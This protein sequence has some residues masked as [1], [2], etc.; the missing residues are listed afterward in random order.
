MKYLH[1]LGI[2]H[3]DLKPGNVL[4]DD[5]LYPQICDF[6]CSFISDKELSKIQMEDPQGTPIYMAP[7]LYSDDPYSYQVDIYAFSLIMY[8][9]ITGIRPFSEY[10]SSYK[11]MKDVKNGVRPKLPKDLDENISSF[12]KRCW[13]NDPSERPAF[14]EIVEFIQQ[15]NFRKIFDIDQDELTNYLKNFD[16]DLKNPFLFHNF[17]VK[18]ASE[19]GDVY[20]THFMGIKYLFGIGVEKNSK[21]AASYFEK[22][23]N[24][25]DSE[26]MFNLG[27]M[28]EKGNDIEAD[29][30][31]ASS[32]YRKAIE[33]GNV[34]AMVNLA[35][36]LKDGK[37]IKMNIEEAAKLFK[38]AADKGDIESMNNYGFL[39]IEK[40]IKNDNMNEA[41]FYFKSA[42]DQGNTDAMINYGRSLLIN[43]AEKNYLNK[44]SLYFKKAAN[45][46]NNYANLLCGFMLWKG[47]GGKK[48][49]KNAIQYFNK[50]VDQA[51]DKEYGI[52]TSFYQIKSFKKED[53]IN[54]LK[55]LADDKKCDD[56]IKYEHC[57]YINDETLIDFTELFI[58]YKKSSIKGDTFSMFA[59]G[60]MMQ[61]GIGIT[62]N[63]EEGLSY[64]KM[65]ADHGNIP[66]MFEYASQ[67]YKSQ[68]FEEASEYFKLAADYKIDEKV[69][70]KCKD[71][72]FESI[73]QSITAKHINDAIILKGDSQYNKNKTTDEILGYFNYNAKILS[74]FF[75]SNM[76]FGMGISKDIEKA[77]RYLKIGIDL[78]DCKSMLR[79]GLMLHNGEGIPINKEESIKYFKMAADRGNVKAYHYYG[80]SLLNGIGIEVNKTEAAKYLKMGA[81]AND[82]DSSLLYGIMLLDGDGIPANNKESIKYIKSA[83]DNGNIKAYYFYGKALYNG[84]GVTKN[85]KE[86]IK[87]FKKGADKK[88]IDAMMAYSEVLIEGNVVPKNLKEGIRIL[89]N[90]ADLGNVSSCYKYGMM[91]SE[92]ILIKKDIKEAIKY[93][94]VA[95]EKND[96]D[97][98]ISLGYIYYIGDGVPVNK[99]KALHYIKQ[100]AELGQTFACFLYGHILITGDG[101][102]C[103]PNEA[104]QYM[105]ISADGNCEF[106]LYEY[107][108][109]LYDGVGV[110]KDQKESDKY[111]ETAIKQYG[112]QK[113]REFAEMLESGKV[114]PKYL[115]ASAFF[116]KKLADKGDYY[117]AKMYGVMRMGNEFSKDLKEAAKY[118]KI[119]ADH[120]LSD[121]MLLY[122]TIMYKNK[123]MSEAIKYYTKSAQHG[124][125][126]AALI[127]SGL[128]HQ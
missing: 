46:G 123:N 112:I 68:N 110:E 107:S 54:Y 31:K 128:L 33:C 29:Y 9:L 35:F 1:S 96:R 83:I 26:S 21:I 121:A 82:P 45:D 12:I 43:K 63:K 86:G 32:Y 28:Y 41:S 5:N 75:Y 109:L 50:F 47:Y 25:G 74:I 51:K 93:F 127:L 81:D 119:A 39:I 117:S 78:G 99:E 70:M 77:V 71:K 101:V 60:L 90:C 34:N 66:A 115:P 37:G 40:Q 53:I 59:C 124:N 102:Q 73:N 89:K 7:E 120:D 61:D 114:F 13:A 95:V 19:E 76:L 84:Y 20:A 125:K 98:L 118:L 62:V 56:F 91:L 36:M 49:K 30:E 126:H 92:G 116:Y 10:K 104:A 42:A 15:D 55:L 64:I 106:G 4:L 23:A 2:I 8:E 97:S 103:N 88:D 65:A 38:M 48:D 17:D 24:F 22:A 11:L 94:L 79:Y 57:Q 14:S 18:K 105:R 52:I 85:Q 27:R 44:A 80:Y 16:D 108:Y 6:G 113:L 72:S 69:V 122:A 58:N 100:S 111:F 67:L 87:Y 3:R